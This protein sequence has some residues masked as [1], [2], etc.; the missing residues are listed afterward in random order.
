MYASLGLNEL[1]VMIIVRYPY[2]EITGELIECHY[3]RM[4]YTDTFWLIKIIYYE[5]GHFR[6]QL[7]QPR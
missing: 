2:F 5:I 6:A 7:I 1:N 4:F 3:A